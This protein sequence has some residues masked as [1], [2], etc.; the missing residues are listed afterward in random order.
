MDKSAASAGV[1]RG[2][3]ASAASAVAVTQCR[4]VRAVMAVRVAIVTS[5]GH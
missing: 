2:T 3:V 4:I 5:P 1:A